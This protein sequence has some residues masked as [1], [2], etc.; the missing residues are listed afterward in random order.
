MLLENE[1]FVPT[2]VVACEHALDALGELACEAGA[3]R[4]LVV[5]GRSSA[6]RSGV[7]DRALELL[8]AAGVAGEAFAGA[9]PEPESDEVDRA[10]ARAIGVGADLVVGLGGG[11]AIDVAKLAAV[12]ARSGG[13]CVDY[14]AGRPVQDSLP[15]VAVPT[16]AGSGSEATPY[17]VVSNSDSGRKFTVT[18]TR[19]FPGIA[20]VDPALTVGA[21]RVVT[22]APG[23]DAWVHALEATLS[24]RP[25]SL[26]EPI[27][28]RVLRLVARFLPIA[29]A[30]PFHVEARVRLSEAATLAGMVIAHAR[31][32]LVHTASVA[33]AP[34]L[35]LPHGLLNAVL[36]PAVLAFN[37]PSYGGR[38]AGA[39]CAMGLPA[40]TDEEAIEEIRAWLDALGVPGDP[41]GNRLDPAVVPGLVAR[42]RQ[43]A[44][45]AEVNVRCI[46]D[47][48]LE[49]LFLGW[50]GAATRS[51]A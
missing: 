38:L 19:L 42:V 27:A 3:R 34:H 40:R 25:T 17:A 12:V 20:L 4:A 23:L 14:E 10:A 43:D 44:G 8:D 49:S 45:L 33:L 15:V 39:A 29:L 47:A 51:A 46:S 32:G 6:S 22:L 11:S 30:E 18:D 41:A 7:L 31:T 21:P 2:R 24:A 26:V 28:A 5:C 35:R 1:H 13:E 9:S 36:V 48:D 37:L 16:T 50:I